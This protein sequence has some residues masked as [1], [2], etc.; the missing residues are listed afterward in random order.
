MLG[1]L[2]A[3]DLRLVPGPASC[4]RSDTPGPCARRARRTPRAIILPDYFG[5]RALLTEP[6]PHNTLRAVKS[7]RP[8]KNSSEK[9]WKKS[10]PN[11]CLR[12]VKVVHEALPPLPVTQLGFQHPQKKER[13]IA[14]FARG[15]CNSNARILRLGKPTVGIASACRLWV[16]D[17]PLPQRQTNST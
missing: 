9:T 6:H 5:S 10:N 15:F 16:P 3:S 14:G 8:P 1:Q 17:G 13:Q 7:A 11:N 2:P 12:C 4:G